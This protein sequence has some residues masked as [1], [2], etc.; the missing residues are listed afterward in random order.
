MS[1]RGTCNYIE[2][3]HPTGW[4]ASKCVRASHA[5]ASL[6]VCVR[7]CAGTGIKKSLLVCVNRWLSPAFWECNFLLNINS[8]ANLQW[9]SKIIDEINKPQLITFT[10]MCKGS[11]NNQKKWQNYHFTM[12][13]LRTHLTKTQCLLCLIDLIY[14]SEMINLNSLS[15][16]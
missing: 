6:C 2:D 7:Y 11:I 9:V 3:T 1:F 13:C 12:L 15:L 14:L 10:Q 4:Q 16:N 8:S 5:S